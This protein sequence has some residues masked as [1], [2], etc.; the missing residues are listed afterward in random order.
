MT[1]TGEF[2]RQT[3]RYELKRCVEKIKGLEADVTKALSITGPLAKALERE[4]IRATLLNM[5]TA[6]AR[7]RLHVRRWVA[8][9]E[10]HR[11]R[12]LADQ[13]N[14]LARVCEEIFPILTQRQTKAVVRIIMDNA[15]TCLTE[16]PRNQ[17]TAS[18]KA[19]EAKNRG[20]N[21]AKAKK[22]IQVEVISDT[23]VNGAVLTT[24]N[25]NGT[26]T[27]GA[28]GH[29]HDVKPPRAKKSRVT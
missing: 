28:N 7:Y 22:G 29:A 14:F 19:A 2:A 15:V 23:I 1:V 25:G 11:F 5:A 17:R 6:H 24:K 16:K 26:H 12:D 21:K 27:N 18:S 9:S 20:G 3:L 10:E 13:G 8:G 4:R